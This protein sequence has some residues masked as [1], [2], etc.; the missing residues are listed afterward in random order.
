MNIATLL[1]WDS[2]LICREKIIMIIYDIITANTDIELIE[3][4]N[5]KIDGGWEPKGGLT[6]IQFGHSKGLW[7]QAIVKKHQ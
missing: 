6:S 5:Q 1:I 3:K 2:L 7:A 4:I